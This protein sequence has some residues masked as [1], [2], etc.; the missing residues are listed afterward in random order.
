MRG[1]DRVRKHSGKNCIYR[2]RKVIYT[3][4]KRFAIFLSLAGMSLT[5]LSLARND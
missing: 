2:H 4:K 5:N 1:G 3:V